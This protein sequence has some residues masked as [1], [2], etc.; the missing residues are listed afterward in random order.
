MGPSR[1]E[2]QWALSAPSDPLLHLLLGI[3]HDQVDQAGQADEHGLVVCSK[4]FLADKHHVHTFFSAEKKSPEIKPV[5]KCLFC[6]SRERGPKKQANRYPWSLGMDLPPLPSRFLSLEK[7]GASPM[8]RLPF[9]TRHHL[10]D[11]TN[12]RRLLLASW[13]HV[14]VDVDAEVVYVLQQLWV[15]THVQRNQFDQVEPIPRP[16][17]NNGVEPVFEFSF[18][19]REATTV[20]RIS[21]LLGRAASCTGQRRNRK[22]NGTIA[23]LGTLAIV[24]S[25]FVAHHGSERVMAP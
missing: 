5:R 7:S 12:P 6:L 20:M 19:V 4:Q 22:T 9:P 1:L 14:L 17:W 16:R 3:H 2:A 23:D 10:V 21:H 18:F 24:R 25:S 8:E 13:C 11:A 15:C